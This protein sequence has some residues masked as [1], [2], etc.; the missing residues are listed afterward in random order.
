MRQRDVGIMER[1]ALTVSLLCIPGCVLVGGKDR[2]SDKII[3]SHKP[4]NMIELT[5]LYPPLHQPSRIEKS[6]AR[7]SNSC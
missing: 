5:D 2:A 3:F 6:V 7:T 4:K 1:K